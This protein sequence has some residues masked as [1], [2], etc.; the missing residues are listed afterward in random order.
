MV[1]S[2]KGKTMSTK[3]SNQSEEKASGFCPALLDELL[4][5][6]KTAQELLGSSRSAC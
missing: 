3:T 4:G 2:T 1:E 5:E 6:A